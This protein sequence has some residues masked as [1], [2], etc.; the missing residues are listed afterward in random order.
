[1]PSMNISDDK[2]FYYVQK[3]MNHLDE[4][5]R[6]QQLAKDN[7]I[8]IKNEIDLSEDNR[9]RVAIATTAMLLAKRNGDPDYDMLCRTGLQ[10][11]EFKSRVINKYKDEA[12]QLINRVENNISTD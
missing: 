3:M 6:L 8:E 5:N 2:I 4:T 12:R 7:G 11:R 1:M 10:K 9:K